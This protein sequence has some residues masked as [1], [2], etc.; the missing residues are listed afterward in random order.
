[1]GA[2][3]GVVGVDAVQADQI[4]RTRRK[5]AEHRQD[6]LVGVE[7]GHLHAERRIQ[8]HAAVHAELS[9]Q[10]REGEQGKKHEPEKFRREIHARKKQRPENEHIFKL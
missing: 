10:K 3:A 1:M 2:F 7:N 4:T 9:A 5:K 8:P 6:A